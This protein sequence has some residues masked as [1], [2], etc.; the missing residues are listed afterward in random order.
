MMYNFKCDNPECLNHN[1]EVEINISLDDYKNVQKCKYCN[2]TLIRIYS[3][4]IKTNDGF[5]N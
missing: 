2:Y 3:N 1:V 4:A 5:K